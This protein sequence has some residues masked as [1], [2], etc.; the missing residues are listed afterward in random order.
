MISWRSPVFTLLAVDQRLLLLSKWEMA[1]DFNEGTRRPP[2]RR[3]AITDNQ[4]NV[5]TYCTNNPGTKFRL[6]PTSQKGR[7][8][9]IRTGKMVLETSHG[10]R[11]D[12]GD[13]SQ[14]KY[15]S[16]FL[17]VLFW[18]LGLYTSMAT[19]ESTQ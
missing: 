5:L 17:S 10:A 3:D 13:I 12:I 19:I 4:I 8:Q 15:D 1:E 18:D 7:C 9:A 14:A 2:I 6:F 11:H 16:E